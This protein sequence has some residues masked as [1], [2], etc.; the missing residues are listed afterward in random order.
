MESAADWPLAPGAIA[1]CRRGC[2]F[3][4]HTQGRTDLWHR[5]RRKRHAQ[6]RRFRMEKRCATWR[7]DRRANAVI[8]RR[9]LLC[10]ERLE[11]E[12]ISGRSEDRTAEVDSRNPRPQ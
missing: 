4:V 1:C 6:R 5:R 12:R 8:L 9:R 7:Y 10:L 2:Y 11:E 3:G